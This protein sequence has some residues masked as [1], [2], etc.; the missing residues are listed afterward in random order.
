MNWWANY[1]KIIRI[2]LYLCPAAPE[3]FFTE[4]DGGIVPRKKMGLTFAP[5]AGS[6]RMRRVINKQLTEQEIMDTF[7]EVFQK[8][9]LSIKLYFMV[10]LPTETKEDIEAVGQLVDK[11]RDQARKYSGKTPQIRVNAS[12]FVPK[13][14]HPSNGSRRTPKKN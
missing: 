12:T 7:T 6:D 1:P 8:G 10:G 3:Q 14:T 2:F 5:E 9:W 11:I 13:A 4:A